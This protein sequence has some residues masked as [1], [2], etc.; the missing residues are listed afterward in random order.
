MWCKP[1][2]QS[3]QT[4]MV[5]TGR[6]QRTHAASRVYCEMETRTYDSRCVFLRI[7]QDSGRPPVSGTPQLL[8]SAKRCVVREPC[9]CIGQGEKGEIVRNLQFVLLLYGQGSAFR[10]FFVVPGSDQPYARCAAKI[11]CDAKGDQRRRPQ[12]YMRR[13]LEAGIPR[14]V[15]RKHGIIIFMTSQHI[16][17][18]SNHCPHRT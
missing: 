18:F 3:V 7:K 5:Q 8:P 10:P 11:L 2:Q 15:S 12:R 6:T 16:S 13:S 1:S 14:K 9:V 4:T 17:T